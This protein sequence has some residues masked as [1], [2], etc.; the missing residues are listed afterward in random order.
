MLKT[1]RAIFENQDVLRA[2]SATLKG[3]FFF[4]PL[5]GDHF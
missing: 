1:W 5:E 2:I 3:M 4:L